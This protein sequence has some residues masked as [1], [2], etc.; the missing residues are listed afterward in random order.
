LTTRCCDE[1]GNP[2][3]AN[4]RRIAQALQKSGM[5]ADEAAAAASHR[6]FSNAPG[7]YGTGVPHLAMASTEWDDDAVLAEQFLNSSRYAYG[8]GQWGQSS[9]DANLLAE[10]L[11]G[12]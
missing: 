10:Q 4:S 2:I 12:M 6:I 7:E 9:A 5:P 8:V 3:A 1:P 11:R